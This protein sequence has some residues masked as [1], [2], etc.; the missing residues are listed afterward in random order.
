METAME[1]RFTNTDEAKITFDM[2]VGDFAELR[3]ILTAAHKA[4]LED[5]SNWRLRRMIKALAEAQGKVADA[6][7]HEAKALSDAAKL[8]DDF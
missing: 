8:A 4:G 3:A 7:A 5:V 1:Y 2:K 6:L